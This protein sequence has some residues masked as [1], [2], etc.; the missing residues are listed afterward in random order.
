MFAKGCDIDSNDYSGFIE[1][2]NISKKAD[3]ILMVL[4]EDYNMSGE[5]ASRTNINFGIQTEL[6]KTLRDELPNKEF[7][8]FDEW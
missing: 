8:N 4:G 2:L 1:A 7:F 6:I 5:A 3:K